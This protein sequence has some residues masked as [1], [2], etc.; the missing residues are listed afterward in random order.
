MLCICM[1]YITTSFNQWVKKNFKWIAYKL[2]LIIGRLSLIFIFYYFLRNY[3][4]LKIL[5]IKSMSNLSYKYHGLACVLRE[6]I[7][8]NNVIFINNNV[9]YSI[10]NLF[11]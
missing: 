11:N 10:Y 9:L 3:V 1:S 7:F 5:K 2:F 8:V 4:T 6:A